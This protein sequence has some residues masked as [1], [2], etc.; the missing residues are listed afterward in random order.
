MGLSWREEALLR[1]IDACLERDDPPL[2]HRFATFTSAE[3]EHAVSRRPVRSA[4]VIVAVA[5]AAAVFLLTLV[6]LSVRPPCHRT[7]T[8]GGG[9]SGSPPAAGSLSPVSSCSSPKQ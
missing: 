8:V 7:A 2:A 6:V 1:H 4:V 9:T 5:L 3:A